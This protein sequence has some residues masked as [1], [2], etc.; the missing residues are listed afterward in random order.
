MEERAGSYKEYKNY[1]NLGEANLR[2]IHSI[3]IDY[4]SKLSPDAYVLIYI[5]RENDSFYETK[6]LERILSDENTSGKAIKSLS[7]EIIYNKDSNTDDNQNSADRKKSKAL[8]AFSK[9]NDSKIRFMASH[10]SRDW[11][12]LLID[13]LDSQVQRVI[14]NKPSRLINIYAL[15]MMVGLF[16]LTIIMSGVIF[17]NPEKQ[18]N[19][20]LLK[21]SDIEQ[22]LNFLIEKVANQHNTT[23]FIMPY[24]FIGM[25]TFVFFLE[26]KPIKRLMKSMDIS[27]FYWGDMMQIYD[28]YLHRRS[29]IK[30]GVIIAFI[31]SLA[32][33][34]VA[35]WFL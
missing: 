6:D 23:M 21:A 19:V 15:D 3:L 29:Q 12:F 28:A 9:D 25:I 20:E 35:S 10:S 18:V 26:F 27:T 8:I 30:W 4:A 2:K 5:V 1:F 34:F 14:K 31:V 7:L 13:E 11:C 22:K 24:F 33:S 32:A 16:I 17:Y